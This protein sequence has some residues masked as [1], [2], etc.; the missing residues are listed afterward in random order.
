MSDTSNVKPLLDALAAAAE[1]LHCY[2]GNDRK[3]AEE[4]VG[5][6]AAGHWCGS[7][8]NSV[9]RNGELRA[10]IRTLLAEWGR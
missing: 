2:Q 5:R 3:T 8:D 7:C 10:E 6:F 1:T 4:M 9:D